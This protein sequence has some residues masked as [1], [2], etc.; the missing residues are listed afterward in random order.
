MF[1]S[2]IRLNSS[3]DFESLSRPLLP[4][5]V[6]L[7]ACLVTMSHCEFQIQG[8]RGLQAWYRQVHIC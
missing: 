1:W 5:Q 7:M 4:P 6:L 3:P 8:E 2:D